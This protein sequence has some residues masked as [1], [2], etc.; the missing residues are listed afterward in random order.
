MRYAVAVAEER[1]FTRAAA[2]C[3]VVQSALSHQIKA[4]EHEIGAQLFA[5]TSRKVELTPAGAAFVA[6]ARVSLDAAARAA[7]DAAAATGIIRGTLTVGVIPTVSA[8][9]LPAVVG[10]FHREH[11]EVHVSIR[12]GSSGEF[13]DEIHAGTMDVAVLGLPT[14]R[15]PDGVASTLLAEERHV[16]VLAADHRLARRKRLSLTDLAEDRFVDF[17]SGSAGR[18]Q[19][20]LAFQQAGLGREVAFE[21]PSLD[22]MLGLVENNLAVAM[23]PPDLVRPGSPLRTVALSGGPSR[24][25]YLAWGNFN[26]SPATLAFVDVAAASADSGRPAR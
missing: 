14:G 18:D 3:F 5:R 13:I 24:R 7:A 16:A 20:D 17:P 12:G 19:S 23:L 1:S 9:D 10:R 25:Q 15:A 4:L 6:A 11:P 8:I 2:R 21:T 22:L 26:P